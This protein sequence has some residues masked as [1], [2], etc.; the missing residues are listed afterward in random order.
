MT[1]RQ[2]QEITQFT[3]R[4]KDPI[5]PI[6]FTSTVPFSSTSNNLRKHPIPYLLLDTYTQIPAPFHLG[7][8]NCCC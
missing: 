5:L 7:K 6:A 2:Q 1:D 8:K 4:N 3:L